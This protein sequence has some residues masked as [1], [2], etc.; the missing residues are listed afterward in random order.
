VHMRARHLDGPQGA[1]NVNVNQAHVDAVK[2]V[3][4]SATSDREGMENARV[5]RRRDSEGR[6]DKPPRNARRRRTRQG[7][8]DTV[9]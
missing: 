2:W 4:A 5:G 1:V 8:P 3:T 7:M 6:A 9:G